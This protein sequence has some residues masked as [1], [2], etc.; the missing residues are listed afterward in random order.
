MA[1]IASVSFNSGKF[2]EFT[3]LISER[4]PQLNLAIPIYYELHDIL[5]DA[6]SFEGEFS[7]LS[8]D[9]SKAVT[10]GI[11]KYRKYYDILDSQDLYYIALV[12]DPRFKTVL[13]DNELPE[14]AGDIVTTI[15]NFLHEQYPAA[16]P[17]D[18]SG[19][20]VVHTAAHDGLMKRVL[21]KV[22]HQATHTSDIDKYFEEGVVIAD[23]STTEDKNWLLSWWNMHK[24]VYPRMAAA[25]RD[26][27]CIPAGEVAVERL[28]SHGR[29]LLGVRR[30]SLN[31]DT[32]R[33]LVILRDM[34]LAEERRN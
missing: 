11:Q 16:N 9:I 27:L 5:E 30:S 7:D 34:F 32:M 26:Y 19:S 29:D 2:N 23:S 6:A 17:S 21:G 24:N 31:G 33:Q 22:Q 20:P 15:R 4:Q 28:F 10:A 3:L 13:L 25:A 8:P 18:V 12:L 1:T 14:A